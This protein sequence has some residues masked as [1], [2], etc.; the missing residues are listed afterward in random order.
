MR[1]DSHAVKSG[2][3][4]EVVLVAS[5]LLA[6]VEMVEHTNSAEVRTACEKYMARVLT[7]TEN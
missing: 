5:G 1:R 6:A 3:A 4:A 2:I 7:E